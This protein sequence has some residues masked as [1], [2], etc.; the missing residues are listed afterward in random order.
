M[1]YKVAGTTLFFFGQPFPIEL[2][3]VLMSKAPWGVVGSGS[4]AQT[5][6]LLVRCF[7]I[8]ASSLLGL[9][10]SLNPVGII[11]SA[12]DPWDTGCPVGNGKRG[13]AGHSPTSLRMR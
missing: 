6:E 11:S 12:P 13:R 3:S 1:T 7:G 9:L 5:P 10:K 2:D 4:P 8:S